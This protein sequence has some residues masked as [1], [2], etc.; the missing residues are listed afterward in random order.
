MADKN[1][2]TVERARFEPGLDGVGHRFRGAA[3][4]ALD[5]RGRLAVETPNLSTL[6]AA[7]TAGLGVTCRTPIFLREADPITSGLPPLPAIAC[8]VESTADLSGPGAHLADLLKTVVA[9][10]IAQAE[11]SGG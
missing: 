3:I 7:V 11:K 9:T 8:R 6:R 5:A 1:V 2:Q 4:A 10:T